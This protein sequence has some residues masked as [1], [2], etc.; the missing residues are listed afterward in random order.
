M[1]SLTNISTLLA[2]RFIVVPNYQRAY[3]WDTDGSEKS[4]K[5]V[6]TFLSDLHDYVN[7]HSVTPYYLGHFLFEER[8]G[9]EYAI[10]DGQQRLTTTVI[11]LSALYKRLREIRN[12]KSVRDFDDDLYVTY[13]NTV[14]QGNQ[15]RFSTVDYD[16][17]MFRDYVIDQTTYDHNSNDT[18]SK[19]R[20]AAAFDYFTSRF[21]EMDEEKLLELLRAITHASCTTHVVTEAAE[22]VQMFIFQ[23]NRGK[24]PTNLEVVKAQFMYHIHL[25]ASSEEVDQILLEIT[26][27]F[28]HIYKSIS[29]VEK[30]LDEDNVLSYAIKI[31]RNNLDDVSSN[32][33]VN[34]KLNKTDGIDFIKDF[35]RLL[36]SCFAQISRFLQQEKENMIYHALLV[37]AERSIMFPFIIKAMLKGMGQ[38][39]LNKLSK[40][41]EQIFLR[42]SII[43][44]RANLLWRLNDCYRNM[45]C[46]A[47]TVVNHIEW[48]KSRNDWWGYWNDAE[49]IR[50]LNMGMNHQIAKVL[51]W[52]YENHLIISG[53][54]GYNPIR[55]DSIQTPHLEHIAP[56]TE[57]KETN[58]GY[59]SYDGDFYNHY[60]EVLGNYMLISG[61]HNMSLSNERFQ[62]KRDSYTHLQQQIEVRDMT[63]KDKTWDKEKIRI[64]HEKILSFLISVL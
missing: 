11:F 43:G 53:K 40:T 48:M 4:L 27:R 32:D 46:D 22:A 33:F 42:N 38:G 5:Q 20:I 28:E 16:N 31:F 6:N 25:H 9:N 64:R 3:S 36:A 61:R 17:Q 26:E 39:D 18:L 49:L 10:I 13:C 8:M 45:D 30:Y 60:L 2:G 54:S 57:N 24:K 34:N 29:Q 47:M 50:S 58:N 21:T 56:Q 41:L 7:S 14:K 55:Y 52:K 59:C 62:L 37:S 63:E 15:Y 23:N 35:T 19:A 51:L 44:T 12:T 1:E